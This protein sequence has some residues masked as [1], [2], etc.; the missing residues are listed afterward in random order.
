MQG[1]GTTYD[2]LDP[3]IDM[4]SSA[5]GVENEDSSFV[6]NMSKYKVK[7]FYNKATFPLWLF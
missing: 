6:H 7:I 1:V 4:L 2:L 3:Q 5:L